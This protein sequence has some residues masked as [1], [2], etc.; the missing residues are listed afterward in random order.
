MK[1]ASSRLK[2]AAY[3]ADGNNNYLDDNLLCGAYRISVYPG[4]QSGD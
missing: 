2:G 1:T 3:Y 4:G